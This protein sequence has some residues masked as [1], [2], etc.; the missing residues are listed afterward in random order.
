[1]TA[2][3]SDPTGSVTVAIDGEGRVVD[4]A[5]AF[6]D[7][8]LRRSAGFA[9]AFH[10][11]WTA[12]RGSTVPPADP[13]TEGAPVRARRVERPARVPLRDLVRPH[14]DRQRS[15]PVGTAGLV[16]EG[17]ERGASDNDCV[18]VVLDAGPSGSLD[19]DQGWLANAT[20]AQVAR[21]VH[22]AFTAAYRS[23]DEEG[24]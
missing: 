8:A 1:M 13:A 12:A 10:T 21:A 15:T 14:L 6:Q 24:R 9:Q 19:L 18:H 23:R 22:Q 11:A 16:I 7:E 2:R 20:G 5:V 4:V 17:G 3:G